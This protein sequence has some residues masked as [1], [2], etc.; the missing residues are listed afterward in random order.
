MKRL[1]LILLIFLLVWAV[2]VVA[3]QDETGIILLTIFLFDRC[4]G[5]GSDNPGCGDCKDV[6][7]VHDIIKAQLGDRLYDGSIEYRI[8]NCRYSA[9]DAACQERGALYGV[10]EDLLALLPIT[11]IGAMNNG[12]YLPGE[13]LF[14]FVKEMLDRYAGGE[15]LNEI[16][17]DILSIYAG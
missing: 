11:F 15:E 6:N 14:P 16:Q 10:P 1:A 2:P 5:C 17:A 8:L 9:N 3:D 7:R 4:G 12:I 13:A